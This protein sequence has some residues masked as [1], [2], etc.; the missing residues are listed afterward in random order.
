MIVI[1]T[2]NY[3]FQAR[4]V[5]KTEQ[6]Y[7]S[8]VQRGNIKSTILQGSKYEYVQYSGEIFGRVGLVCG[9]NPV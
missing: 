6:E 4:A 8:F 5:L 1:L 9:V 2:L 7:L 3:F